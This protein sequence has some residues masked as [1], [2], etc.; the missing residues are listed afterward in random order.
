[1]RR[2]DSVIKSCQLLPIVAVWL[3]L[4]AGCTKW[5]L[6]GDGF[7]NET[8][9]WGEKLR[10]VTKGQSTGFDTRAKEIEANLGVQ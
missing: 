8:A 1:M 6:H 10:P 3:A 4:C 7:G 9:H 2:I 5:N